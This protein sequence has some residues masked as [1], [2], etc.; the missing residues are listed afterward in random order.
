MILNE[1]QDQNM[2]A[3]NGKFAKN[4][5]IQSGYPKDELIEVDA[6]RYLYL[7]KYKKI[8]KSLISGENPIRILVLGDYLIENTHFQMS[9]LERLILPFQILSNLQSNRT[10]TAR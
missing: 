4:C 2:V 3:V 7:N 5:L 1:Y 10:L 9:I 8:N 6:L